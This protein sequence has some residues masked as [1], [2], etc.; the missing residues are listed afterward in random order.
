MSGDLHGKYRSLA[1]DCKAYHPTERTEHA[2]IIRGVTAHR[3]P[4]PMSCECVKR[5]EVISDEE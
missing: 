4:H 5:S 3:H 1:A 2:T